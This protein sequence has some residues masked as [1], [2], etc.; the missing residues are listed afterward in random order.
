ML[1]IFSYLYIFAPT[2][3]LS[4]YF[5]KRFSPL[6]IYLLKNF[7][8]LYIFTKRIVLSIYFCAKIFIS[9]IYFCS[10]FLLFVGLTVSL[11]LNCFSISIKKTLRLLL[12][13]IF[14]YSF[15][16]LPPLLLLSFWFLFFCFLFFWCFS[17]P[18]LPCRLHII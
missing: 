14:V 1:K 2:F 5:C 11:L 9:S 4:I 7:P 15:S 18:S 12:S 6:Y 16:L 10:S 3:L 13:S 8:S 17:I